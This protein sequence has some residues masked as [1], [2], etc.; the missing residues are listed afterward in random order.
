MLFMVFLVNK[1]A[2]VMKNEF[3]ACEWLGCPVVFM[4]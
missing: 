2:P 1:T 4:S 3:D